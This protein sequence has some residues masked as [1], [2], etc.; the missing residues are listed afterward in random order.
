[1]S[2]P[3]YRHYLTVSDTEVLPSGPLDC[4]TAGDHHAAE[5]IF[6]PLDPLASYRVEIV[7]AGGAYDLTERL[8]PTDGEIAV[9]VPYAWT[10]AGI[11]TVRL[12]E[13]EETDGEETARRYFPPVT[14]R[15]GYREEG[16]QEATLQCWQQLV[17]RAEALLREADDRAAAAERAADSAATYA[18]AAE[19]AAARCED[20]LSAV[21]TLTDITSTIKKVVGL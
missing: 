6:A 17:T 3:I 21:E 20:V 4:G 19:T 1:M 2:L 16:E 7:T 10:T 12:V 5:L 18:L 13:V 11:A 14:L 9:L 15:F 8:T